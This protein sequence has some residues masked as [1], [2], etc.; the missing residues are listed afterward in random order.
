MH[1]TPV[2]LAFLIHTHTVTSRRL[3]SPQP[4]DGESRLCPQ[5]VQFKLITDSGAR[6]HGA[7]EASLAQMKLCGLNWNQVWFKAHLWLEY[8]S[9]RLW[10]NQILR[11][12]IKS[13][14]GCVVF[15]LYERRL[16]LLCWTFVSVSESVAE[17]Q[18]S[19]TTIECAFAFSCHVE[20]IYR[21][22]WEFHCAC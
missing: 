10:I 16:W 4:A 13:D 5:T 14:F 12:P 11:C 7:F 9:E 20:H 22:W 8:W 19:F 1:L 18:I 21:G 6:Q 15:M 3:S 17:S 2:T